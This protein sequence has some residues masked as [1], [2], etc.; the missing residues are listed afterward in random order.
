M[1]FET[2]PEFFSWPTSALSSG[3][4]NP[5]KLELNQPIQRNLRSISKTIRFQ[6]RTRLYFGS[7]FQSS[8]MEWNFERLDADSISNLNRTLFTCCTNISRKNWSVL[9]KLKIAYFSSHQLSSKASHRDQGCLPR[10]KHVLCRPQNWRNP[11]STAGQNWL[12]IALIPLSITPTNDALKEK[13]LAN[14]FILL[15]DYILHRNT[16]QKWEDLVFLFIKTS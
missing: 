1:A 16:F 3:G 4:N 6:I 14:L 8:G 15:C 5:L 9:P 12:Q 7:Y 2:T 13:K 10:E 11:R